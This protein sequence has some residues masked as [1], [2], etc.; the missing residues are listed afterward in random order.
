MAAYAL[1]QSDHWLGA[2]YRRMKAWR[3]ALVATKATVRKLAAIFYCMVKE[4]RAFNPISVDEYEQKL[5]ERKR[6][7][8]QQQATKMG[9]NL[10]LI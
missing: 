10:V 1:Q 8:I 3:G 9:M 4:Q 5:A 6:K 7:Y 2:F